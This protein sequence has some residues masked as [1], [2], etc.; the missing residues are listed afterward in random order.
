MTTINYNTGLYGIPESAKYLANTPPLTNG[1]KVN[2]SR[3]RY[4]IRES[5]PHIESPIYPTSKRLVSFVDLIS[6][7]MVAVLRARGVKLKEIKATEIWLRVEFGIPYPLASRG[8]WTYGSHVYIK[9]R[10]NLLAASKYG[11]K[12]MDFIRDWLSE[13][14]LDMTFDVDDIANSWTPYQGISMNPIIQFGEPCI[15]ETRIPTSSIWSNHIAGDSPEIIAKAH[16][17]DVGLV[18]NAI[19]WEKRI[20]AT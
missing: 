19:D 7:R 1:N 12:A 9:F 15:S 10:E 17:I 13:I 4:W 3:L 2:Y 8:L 16:D 5:V 18:V 6:M 11:Q 14:E 20:V